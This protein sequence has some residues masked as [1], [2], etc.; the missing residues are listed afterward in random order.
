MIPPKANPPAQ[1]VKAMAT[2]DPET[3]VPVLT[4]LFPPPRFLYRL[5]VEKF[6]AM[7]ESERLRPSGHRITD[8]TI[9]HVKAVGEVASC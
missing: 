6:E 5:S 2:I 7:V 8:P 4:T 3:P 9:P 1:E